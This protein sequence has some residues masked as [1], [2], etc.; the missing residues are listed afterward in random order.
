MLLRGYIRGMNPK[1]YPLIPRSKR[2]QAMASLQLAVARG[3]HYWTGGSLPQDRARSL[4][5]KLNA[6]FG[7]LMGYSLTNHQSDS[8]KKRHAPR[9]RLVLIEGNENAV[10]WFLLCDQ[11]ELPGE[12]LGDAR[13]RHQRLRYAERYELVR[14]TKPARI[15]G[16]QHW[17]WR[18]VPGVYA[19]HV[20]E[21]TRYAAHESPKRVQALIDYLVTDP[22]FSGLRTQRMQLF[23]RILRIRQRQKPGREGL[24][25]PAL[26]FL[27]PTQA[28]T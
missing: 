1:P 10:L 8:R 15:G 18:Y 6:R 21:G 20:D 26:P 7:G 19:T 25:I 16:G 14:T 11:P 22:G 27:N 12:R 5:A 23:G 2:W 9:P 13:D 17:T 4:A 3:W 24:R 28:R